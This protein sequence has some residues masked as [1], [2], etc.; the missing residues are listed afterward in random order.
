MKL[1]F[2]ASAILNTVKLLGQNAVKVF[3]ENY[4]IRLALYEVGNAIWKGMYVL[5]S[6][7][8]RGRF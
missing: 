5:K 6:I 4:T 2:D 3:R 1:L 7:D 8:R